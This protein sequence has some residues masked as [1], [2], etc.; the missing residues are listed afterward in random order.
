[1]GAECF[2]SRDRKKKKHQMIVVDEDQNLKELI[3][4][5]Q[6]FCNIK[7]LAKYFKNDFNKIQEISS[8]K[9]FQ[10]SNFCLTDY[11][12]DVIDKKWPDLNQ[13]K[14][15]FSIKEEAKEFLAE[16]YEIYPK[17]SENEELLLNLIIMRL[18]EE[19]NRVGDSTQQNPI[20]AK[21]D[22]NTA[23]NEYF[24]Y[25]SNGHR[26]IMSDNF[27]G[28][29]YIHSCCLTCQT[30]FYD[31]Q[32]YIYG[33]YS[34]DQVYNFKTMLFQ[35]APNA[36]TQNNEINIYDCLSYDQQIKNDEKLCK[37]CGVMTN[38][39]IKNI[40]FVTPHILTFIFNKINLPS[41]KFAIYEKININQFVENQ[42][43]INYD[44][45]GIIAIFPQEHYITF[46]KNPIDNQ[47]Y[48]YD[49]TN[50]Q[51]KNNFQEIIC[52]VGFPYMLFY[53]TS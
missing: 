43:N 9:K 27:F 30:N 33:V 42:E 39:S 20:E 10:K 11:L 40:I 47:W 44:L 7:L 53:K 13:L 29:Y 31:F 16:I 12:K 3:P 34:L 1:M 17:Y 50:V 32:P 18:H 14:T 46:C 19:L 24:Q 38:F 5:L 37:K 4:I 52:S 2:E 8:Y 41:V 49:D 15:S 36:M 28:T 21:T 26:S 48:S 6:C 25:F 35:N 45:F 22:K 51:K 23:A